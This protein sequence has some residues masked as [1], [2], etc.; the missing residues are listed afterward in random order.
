MRNINFVLILVIL[1]LRLSAMNAFS[2]PSNSGSECM[3]FTRIVNAPTS[4]S[5]LPTSSLSANGRSSGNVVIAGRLFPFLSNFFIGPAKWRDITKNVSTAVD[6]GDLFLIAVLGWA[7]LPLSAFVFNRRHRSDDP[8]PDF[9]NSTLFKI[10]SLTSQ[11]AKIA[12]TYILQAIGR[13][14]AL[15][16]TNAFPFAANSSV[17]QVLSMSLMFWPS[18]S[19]RLASMFRTIKTLV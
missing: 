19:M 6:L 17:A 1:S 9:R 10:S 4:L 18:L 3:R 8:L 13:H 7:V 15:V 11:I 5:A 12:G 16:L 2:A 14:R